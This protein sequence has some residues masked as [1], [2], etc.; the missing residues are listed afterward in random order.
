M[1]I[2]KLIG[3]LGNQMFQYATGRRLAHVL[4]AEL[5]LDITGFDNYKRRA[6]SLEYF[7][8]Q[9]NLAS[10]EDV[11]TL[12]TLKRG[13]VERVLAKVLHKR[14]THIREK[15][16]HFDPNILNLSDGVYLDGYWQSEMYFADIAQII[17]DE[18][19]VKAPQTGRNKELAKQIGSCESVC[20]SIRRGEYVTD[21]RINKVH[22]VLDLDYYWACVQELTKTVKNPHFFIF[23]DELE[24]ARRNLRLSYDATFV[25][26]NNNRPDQPNQDLSLMS[27]CK[28]HI[29]ANSSFSW[30]GAWLNPRKDK[31][32]FAPKQWFGKEQKASKRTDD[33]LPATWILL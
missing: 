28:H 29:I 8:I 15:H 23:S 11:A 7:N 31:M 14:S 6:Y 30:W 27:Q 25:G 2:T 22:G 16:F 9:E 19:T 20:L 18:F 26:H 17:R 13:I 10:A 1:V 32:V 4:G 5:K 21:P 3:G 24:W 12:R 33:L